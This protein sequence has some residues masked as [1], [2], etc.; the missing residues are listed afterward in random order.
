MEIQKLFQSGRTLA[1]ASDGTNTNSVI[2][3]YQD[4]AA[5]ADYL[6]IYIGINDSHK[7]AAETGNIPL[8]T[9]TDTATSTFYGAWNTILS[10]F[11]A[12]RP[13]L[14]IGIIVSNGCETDDYRTATIAIAQK[15]GI[16]YIDMNGDSRTPCMIRSTNAAIDSGVRNQRTANWKVSNDNTHPNA[17]CHAF[18]A[19]FIEDF[20][21]SL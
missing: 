6:T 13:N 17:A 2:L 4:V 5:D 12:N 14:H 20:L 8:G 7:R 10:W 18:E 19:T 9:I 1:L 15:Y 21:R 16:P 3:S 11:I